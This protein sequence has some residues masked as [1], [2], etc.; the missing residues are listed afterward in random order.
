MKNSRFSHL[1]LVLSLVLFFVV[2]TL[3]QGGE[4]WSWPPGDDRGNGIGVLPGDSE[5]VPAQYSSQDPHETQPGEA[6]ISQLQPMPEDT[7]VSWTLWLYLV[8]YAIY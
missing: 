7:R 5:A 6:A 3:V 4:P 2:G 8:I 1:V